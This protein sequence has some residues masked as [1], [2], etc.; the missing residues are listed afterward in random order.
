MSAAKPIPNGPQDTPPS[1]TTDVR[2]KALE[3][4]PA[5]LDARFLD[6]VKRVARDH[7]EILKAL[8]R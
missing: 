3:A 5:D 2:A 8:A 7:G 1:E 4:R 6:A